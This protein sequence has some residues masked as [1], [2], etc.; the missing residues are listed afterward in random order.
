MKIA[1]PSRVLGI[2]CAFV[3]VAALAGCGKPE[4][5]AAPQVAAPTPPAVVV[6][7]PPAAAPAPTAPPVTAAAPKPEPKPVAAAPAPARQAVVQD[8]NPW[9]LLGQQR[10]A[11]KTDRGK[12]VVGRAKGEFREI[13]IRVEDAPLDLESVVVILVGGERLN[14]EFRY[15]FTQNSKSR[16]VDLPGGRRFIQRVE[17]TYRA[18][19]R[20]EGAATVQLYGR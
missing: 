15:Q 6:V 16:A 7:P 3:V 1:P 18:I 12:I 9:R 4:E 11:F 13:Q 8:K 2:F 5:K 19:N 14:P 17:Y 10:A 20:R